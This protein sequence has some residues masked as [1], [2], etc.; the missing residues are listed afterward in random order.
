MG[1]PSGPSG[2][3]NPRNDASGLGL[4]VFSQLPVRTV[5]GNRGLVS[6]GT[7]IMLGECTGHVPSY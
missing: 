6:V 1:C 4:F 2:H 7:A 3:W 5:S